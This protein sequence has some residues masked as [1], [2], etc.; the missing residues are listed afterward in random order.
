MILLY[1][2]VRFASNRVYLNCAIT[3]AYNLK[4][5]KGKICRCNNNQC[6]NEKSGKTK[7]GIE[8]GHPMFMRVFFL[9]LRRTLKTC[10]SKMNW[11]ERRR[12]ISIWSAAPSHQAHTVSSKHT[13]VFTCERGGLHVRFFAQLKLNTAAFSRRHFFFSPSHSFVSLT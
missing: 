9:I 4:I 3:R 10:R 2:S 5:S 1:Q 12:S 11:Y 13:S 8:S 6:E 7:R